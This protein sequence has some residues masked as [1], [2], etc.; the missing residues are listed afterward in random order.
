MYVEPNRLPETGIAYFFTA[1]EPT[2]EKKK[3][4]GK[5]AMIRMIRVGSES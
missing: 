4:E 3:S 5:T 1:V 2:E